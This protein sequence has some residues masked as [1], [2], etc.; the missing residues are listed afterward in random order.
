MCLKYIL[1]KILLQWMS[2]EKTDKILFWSAFTETQMNST[3]KRNHSFSKLQIV[4]KILKL[5]CSTVSWFLCNLQFLLLCHYIGRTYLIPRGHQNYQ[6]FARMKTFHHHCGS[7]TS[8]SILHNL[9]LPVS[10]SICLYK[11][12]NSRR[13]R[14][15]V[16]NYPSILNSIT[17]QNVSW[18]VYRWSDRIF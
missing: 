11:P 13:T 1:K 6:N 12:L 17:G 7:S 5:F 2:F 16:L 14:C 4:L 18:Y 15:P 8:C 10:T 9:P 3:V